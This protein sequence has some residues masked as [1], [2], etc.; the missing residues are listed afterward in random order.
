MRERWVVC[1]LLY[2]LTLGNAAPMVAQQAPPEDGATQSTSD[3]APPSDDAAADGT[4]DDATGTTDDAPDTGRSTGREPPLVGDMR[5]AVRT[6]QSHLMSLDFGDENGIFY[7]VG[8]GLLAY[9]ILVSIFLFVWRRARKPMFWKEGTELALGEGRWTLDIGF[10][11]RRKVEAW[12]ELQISRVEPQGVLAELACLM[13]S[14][15]RGRLSQGSVVK[16]RLG[17][18]EP[19]KFWQ[20]SEMDSL[21]LGFELIQP[22]DQAVSVD[23]E[24]KIE[25]VIGRKR[26]TGGQFRATLGFEPSDP[27]ALARA[28][29]SLPEP[30]PIDPLA[31]LDPSLPAG[32]PDLPAPPAPLAGLPEP[33]APVA[34]PDPTALRDLKQAQYSLDKRLEALESAADGAQA[35]AGSAAD[36]SLRPQLEALETRLEHVLN[37]GQ[38]RIDQRL[39]ELEARVTAGGASGD[40]DPRLVDRML[41]DFE[42]KFRTT[43]Q[44][45]EEEVER[46]LQALETRG[47]E[48]QGG[49]GGGLDEAAIAA[50]RQESRATE[51]RL[52]AD[53]RENIQ[54]LA[55]SIRHA[56][57][58]INQLNATVNDVMQR[59]V[60]IERRVADLD[61]KVNATDG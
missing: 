55:K 39:S 42:Q 58:Q 8:A 16:V 52:V 18:L 22:R 37:E 11:I 53:M 61:Q 59:F 38:Q 20:R 2:C 31:D 49:G 34:A 14:E 43:L 6:G 13:G 19:R 26:D 46:R 15:I 1:V 5:E 44:V 17:K 32:L 45:R 7:M 50:L 51:Q 23:V 35:T 21:G 3:T 60:N 28:A 24:V 36:E 56:G 25:Y 12:A 48:S 40:F 9:F 57:S 30:P 4:V 54:I 10:A 47:L 41:Q 27:F 33:G 29:A